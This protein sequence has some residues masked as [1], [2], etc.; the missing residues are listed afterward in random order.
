VFSFITGFVVYALMAKAGLE[1][2]VVEG[3][4][5]AQAR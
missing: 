5:I 4:R 2:K 1:P 3:H